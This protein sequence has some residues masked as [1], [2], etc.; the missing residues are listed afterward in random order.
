MANEQAAANITAD[1]ILAGRAIFTVSN[2]AGERYTYKITKKQDEGRQPV[3][4]VALLT[5]SNNETDYTYMGLISLAARTVISTRNS[6]ISPDVV[7]FKVAQWAVAMLLQG[8][9]IPAGYSIHHEGK[10]GR[11]GRTLTVPESIQTGLGPECAGKMGLVAP[12]KAQA[13]ERQR[14]LTE[15]AQAFGTALEDSVD[16]AE[17]ALGVQ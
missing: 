1:F 14:T 3:Y 15:V 10:C 16:R 4:F 12:A 11:C 9:A 17:R 6:R 5:G 2:P 13:A 7:S 8:R